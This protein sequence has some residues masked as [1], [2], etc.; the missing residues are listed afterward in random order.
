MVCICMIMDCL[1]CKFIYIL[2]A[3]SNY[4]YL[5]P[6]WTKLECIVI[7]IEIPGCCIKS[8]NSFVI[9]GDAIPIVTPTNYLCNVHAK[10]KNIQVHRK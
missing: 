6:V 10:Q 1:N 3:L 5:I 9:S 8:S 2:F 7:T 4:I